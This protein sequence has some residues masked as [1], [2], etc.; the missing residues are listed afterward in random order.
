MMNIYIIGDPVMLLTVII[1]ASWR[2]TDM[3][4]LPTEDSKKIGLM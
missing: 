1:Y 3:V 4:D 2:L